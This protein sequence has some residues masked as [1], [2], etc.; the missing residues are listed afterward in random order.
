MDKFRL[1]IPRGAGFV[2]RNL[3]RVLS[4]GNYGMKEVTVL[5]KDRENLEYVKKHGVKALCVDLA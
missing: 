5:D 4:S 2:G 1:V 3:I